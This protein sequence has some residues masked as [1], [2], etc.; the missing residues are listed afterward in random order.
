[1]NW[2]NSSP[3]PQVK[4]KQEIEHRVASA[5][6]KVIGMAVTYFSQAKFYVASGK[7]A[8]GKAKWEF[9]V[10]ILIRVFIK[11]PDCV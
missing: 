9:V 3:L 11:C 10:G 1:M 6:Y 8:P 4:S 5:S 7:G 2:G